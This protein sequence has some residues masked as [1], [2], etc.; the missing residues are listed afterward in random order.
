MAK[1]HATWGWKDFLIVWSHVGED[2]FDITPNTLANEA[3]QVL[4]NRGVRHADLLALLRGVVADLPEFFAAIAAEMTVIQ[5]A[6]AADEITHRAEAAV[7]GHERKATEAA[8]G[9]MFAGMFDDARLPADWATLSGDELATVAPHG[10]VYPKAKVTVTCSL[11]SAGETI[12]A[13]EDTEGWVCDPCIEES[14]N[15]D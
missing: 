8:L 1:H 15:E 10:T 5:D 6:E 7:R 14:K 9:N 4:H 13:E 2:G 3:A 12:D 11:C